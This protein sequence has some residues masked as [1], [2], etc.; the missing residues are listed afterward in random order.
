MIKDSYSQQ[1]E[2]LKSGE[3]KQ[4]ETEQFTFYINNL[5]LFHPLFS[6][7]IIPSCKFNIAIASQITNLL[8]C[9][10]KCTLDSAHLM[11]NKTFILSILRCQ[12]I[13]FYVSCI[14]FVSR[15]VVNYYTSSTYIAGIISMLSSTAV[16]AKNGTF[17]QEHYT[18]QKNEHS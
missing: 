13:D 2:A 14:T 6:L 4:H 12:K 7:R 11:A 10:R 5:S 8:S 3:K 17:Q 9:L 16:I 15:S 1:V 18:I